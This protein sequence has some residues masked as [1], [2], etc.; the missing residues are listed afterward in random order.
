ML[1][2]IHCAGTPREIGFK[3]GSEAKAKIQGTLSFYR[4]YFMRKANLDWD[5]ACLN[6]EKFMPLLTRDWSSLVEEMEGVAEGSGL[7][8][9]SILAINVRTEISMGMMTDGCTALAWKTDSE[10]LLAQNWDWEVPQQ[11]NL[12]ALHIHRQAPQTS[13]SQVTEAGIIGKIGLNSSGVGV[14]LNAIR[15]RGIS[16]SR[17]PAH[18]AL[19]VGLDSTSRSE[20]VERLE[21]AG[22]GAAAHILIADETGGTSMEF[23]ALDL[24]KFEMRDGKVAHTNHFL[25]QHAEGVAD[26]TFLPDSKE[27]MQRITELMARETTAGVPSVQKMLQDE[28]NLPGAINRVASEKSPSATLFSIVMD[29]KARKAMVKVGRPTECEDT[30]VLDAGSVG[31]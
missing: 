19:R 1:Q 12:I 8:F 31:E 4:E 17:L 14:C 21:K 11:A 20:A 2:E 25:V 30:L 5:A 16:Y 9:S 29:L 27:R 22:L 26:A 15:A 18:L 7:S 6:A 13:I 23:S 3:H 10:A 24:V 28:M